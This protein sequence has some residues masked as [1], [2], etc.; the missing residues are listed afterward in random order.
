MAGMWNAFS[1]SANGLAASATQLTS[2]AS[3]FVNAFAGTPKPPAQTQAAPAA[4]ATQASS[5][6]T[7]ATAVAA[8]NAAPSSW[9]VE[10]L[11]AKY[12][13]RA[14]LDALKSA[15]KLT[16]KMIDTIG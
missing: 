7:S 12:A 1:I 10:I 14:N 3:K 13:Y 15:D 5:P 11:S 8:Q 16:Q 4:P 9:M 6:L 2:A